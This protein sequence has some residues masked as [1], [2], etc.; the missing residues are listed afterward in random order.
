MPWCLAGLAAGIAV[1][2]AVPRRGRLSR[3]VRVVAWVVG[4]VVWFGGGIV[5]FAHALS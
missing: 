2:I 1:Q 4:L 5:S 3:M